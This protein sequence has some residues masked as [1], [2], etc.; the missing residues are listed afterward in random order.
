MKINAGIRYVENG[1]TASLRA[2][3]VDSELI[4]IANENVNGFD[5]VGYQ[6]KDP[7]ISRFTEFLGVHGLSTTDFGAIAELHVFYGRLGQGCENVQVF[8]PQSTH[9]DMTITPKLGVSY[10]R[11]ECRTTFGH[12][13]MS[14]ATWI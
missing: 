14:A 1:M 2:M 7:V 9:F 4:G 6:R 3:H 10:V 11:A 8:E 5:K 12:F 13:A